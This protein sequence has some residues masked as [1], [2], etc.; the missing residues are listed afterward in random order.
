MKR[1]RRRIDGRWTPAAPCPVHD[2]PPAVPPRDVANRARRGGR[3]G[4]AKGD[5]MLS[6]QAE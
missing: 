5:G 2:A 1:R 4:D 6:T 3:M